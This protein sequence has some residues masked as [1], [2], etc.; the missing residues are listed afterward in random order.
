ME[1]VVITG[2]AVQLRDGTNVHIHFAV[3]KYVSNLT[4]Q[5]GMLFVKDDS[6]TKE[7]F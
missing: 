5:I 3:V 2:F 6:K 7:R 4:G 1:W